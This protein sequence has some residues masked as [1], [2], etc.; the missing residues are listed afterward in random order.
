M[1]RLE[2]QTRVMAPPPP[3]T[4]ALVTRDN[5]KKKPNQS[6]GQQVP[7]V[8][9]N[10]EIQEFKKASVIIHTPPGS[11][12]LDPIAAPEITNRINNFLN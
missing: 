9:L 6:K 1:D 5:S 4:W 10:A 3:T 7:L 12:V 11:A 8:P 2:R